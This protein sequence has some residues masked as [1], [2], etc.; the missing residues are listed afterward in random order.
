MRESELSSSNAKTSSPFYLS[1]PAQRV[2]DDALKYGR[3]S[4]LAISNFLIEQKLVQDTRMS[5]GKP[6]IYIAVAA[7]LD[8]LSAAGQCELVLGNSEDRVY[9]NSKTP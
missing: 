5:T 4:T 2:V 3:I 7:Y 6:G 1:Q 9:S 8:K